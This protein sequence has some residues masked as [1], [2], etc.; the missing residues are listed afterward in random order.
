MKENPPYVKLGAEK[1]DSAYGPYISFVSDLGTTSYIQM[2][3]SRDVWFKQVSPTGDALGMATFQTGAGEAVGKYFVQRMQQTERQDYTKVAEV[4]KHAGWRKVED[5]LPAPECGVD[6][7]G[8]IGLSEDVLVRTAEGTIVGAWYDYDRHGWYTFG[9]GK[10]RNGF[11]EFLTRYDDQHDNTVIEW[12][13]MPGKEQGRWISSK[14]RMPIAGEYK[15]IEV[16]YLDDPEDENSRTYLI[17]FHD[18]DSWCSVVNGKEHE[19]DY[20]RPLQELKINK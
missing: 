15:Y 8:N 12:R 5:G 16:S 7:D 9:I 6:E 20:W 3:D 2:T 4:D 10:D 19:F 17:Y 13:P 1:P 14:E 18:G 11:N